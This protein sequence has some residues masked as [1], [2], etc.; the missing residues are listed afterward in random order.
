M[1]E[2]HTI[3]QLLD[4]METN[5]FHTPDTSICDCGHCRTYATII[6]LSNRMG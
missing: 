4:Y 5:A 3:G 1:S 2:N 6:H